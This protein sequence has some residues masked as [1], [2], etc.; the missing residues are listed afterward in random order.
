MALDDIL[1]LRS[2]P[3]VVGGIQRQSV[4]TLTLHEAQIKF[5][6][7][8]QQWLIIQKIGIQHVINS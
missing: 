5:Y 6:Q 3:K 4:M 7:I 2:K 8:S 1:Y